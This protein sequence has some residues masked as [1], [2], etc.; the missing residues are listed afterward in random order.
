MQLQ[1]QIQQSSPSPYQPN[2]ATNTGADLY[3][4]HHFNGSKFDQ[5]HHHGNHHH[6]SAFTGCGGSERAASPVQ[7]GNQHS[8]ID[9]LNGVSNGFSTGNVTTGSANNLQMLLNALELDT[10]IGGG[11]QQKVSYYNANIQKQKLV[12]WSNEQKPN[13]YHCNK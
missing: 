12:L 2:G 11:G 1:Q 5:L 3:Q 10:R 7:P 4:L 6:L 13:E 9:G 8:F